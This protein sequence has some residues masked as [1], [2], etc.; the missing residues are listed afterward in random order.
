MITPIKEFISFGNFDTKS[1]G[2]YL[3]SR[4]APSPQEKEVIENLLFSQGILDF[5]MMG[6]ERFFDNRIITYD[7]KLPNKGYNDRKSAEREIKNQLMR[8]G[9]SKLIDTHDKHFH[10]FGKFKSVKVKDDPIKK[11]LIATLEFDCYPFLI[12]DSNYFDDIW[13][14]FS[15]E[16]GV[17]NWT[18]WKLEGE[19][20]VP[21]F[22][23]GDSTIIPEIITTS[24]LKIEKS[25]EM[26]SFSPGVSENVLL[27]IAPREQTILTITGSGYVSIRFAMEVLG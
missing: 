8:I 19:T 21:V 14:D 4:D 2:W 20:K 27:K 24:N 25:G 5:S 22:N 16:Y 26:F 3:E 9:A 15:F 23:P 7:F 1:R 18:R 6:N 11:S 12:A 17:S 13:D 10:W